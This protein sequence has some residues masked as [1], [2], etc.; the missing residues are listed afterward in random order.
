MMRIGFVLFI[1]LIFSCQ[2]PQETTSVPQKPDPWVYIN[3]ISDTLPE[4]EGFSLYNSRLKNQ[5]ILSKFNYDELHFRYKIDT[6]KYILV[7]A[8]GIL[9]ARFRCFAMGNPFTIHLLKNDSIYLVNE[10]LIISALKSDTISTL[11]AKSISPTNFSS[12][13]T[14]GSYF[15]IHYDTEVKKENVLRIIELLEKGYSI[16]L[17]NKKNNFQKLSE[18]EKYQLIRKYPFAM[19]YIIQ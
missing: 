5:S 13:D 14:Y 18:K 3:R 19:L 12:I 2:Q 16:F 10:N 17:N 11:Y 7:T 6:N 1:L 4:V 8:N 9:K 15:M